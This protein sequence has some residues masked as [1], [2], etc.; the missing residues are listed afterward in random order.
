MHAKLTGRWRGLAAVPMDNGTRTQYPQTTATPGPSKFRMQFPHDTDPCTLKNRRIS[1]IRL[2]H[3]KYTQGNCMRNCRNPVRTQHHATTRTHRYR[4]AGG[5]AGPAAVPVD[6][7]ST[8]P[9]QISHAIPP[10]HGSMH[11]QKPQNINDQTST[12]E[13][14]SGELHAKLPKSSQ[15]SA[16]CHNQ[17][18]QVWR[19]PEGRAAVPEGPVW[20]ARAGRRPRVHQA[21][22]PSARKR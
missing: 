21:A 16:P 17:A 12:L 10:R 11:A 9:K 14:H 2:Q 19:T 22:R 6:G 7:S 20:R 4:G 13:I 15:D 8:Q 18:P 5:S 1:T 3:L